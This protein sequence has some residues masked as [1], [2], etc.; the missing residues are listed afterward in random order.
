VVIG[1]FVGRRRTP[2]SCRAEGSNRARLVPFDGRHAMG[3]G[4]RCDA[5]RQ[6]LEQSSYQRSV[7]TVAERV[8]NS[9]AAEFRY[10]NGG[11]MGER[12]RAVSNLKDGCSRRV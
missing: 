10:R 8:G 4:E 3:R 9:H 1:Q 6:V 2:R 7:M 5:R 12:P 11:S